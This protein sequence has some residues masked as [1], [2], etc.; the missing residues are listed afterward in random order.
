MLRG[1]A[2]PPPGIWDSL[3]GMLGPIGM[4]GGGGGILTLGLTAITAIR[5]LREERTVNT[6]MME[7]HDLWV[8]WQGWNKQETD[9][10]LSDYRDAHIAA[11]VRKPVQTRLKKYRK[12]SS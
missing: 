2:A 12:K 5:K 4:L 11:G 9:K 6:G 3:L 7:A 8:D 10:H 1:E